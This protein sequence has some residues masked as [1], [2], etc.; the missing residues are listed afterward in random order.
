MNTRMAR[1][2]AAAGGLAIAAAFAVSCSQAQEA[3]KD[4]A[5]SASS[6]AGAAGSAA[7]SAASAAGSAASSV[8]SAAGSV[9][10][11]VGSAA[12][13]VAS[14]GASAASSAASSAVSSGASAASSAMSSAVE[15]ATTMNVPGVGDVSLDADT[16]AAWTRLGGASGLG[17]PTGMSEKVGDGFMTP[18]ASG[19]IYSSPAGA[20]LVQGEILRVYGEQGGPAGALGFPTADESTTGG[21]PKT[22]NGGWVTEFQ[23]GS[24]SW[25]NDG[26]GS[27]TETVTTN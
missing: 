23:N 10:S 15:G 25:T 2:A 9:A 26:M 21:G 11:S 17:A 13:S 1:A 4:I 6:A 24:I 3:T 7:S 16:A 22:A 20:Y 8:G 5:S 14:S 27:F 19:A 18:F 12:S